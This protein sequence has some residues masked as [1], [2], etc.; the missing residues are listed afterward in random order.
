VLR[1]A[2]SVVPSFLAEVLEIA[3][4]NSYRIIG[5][6][7]TFQQHVASLALAR[8]LRRTA[9]DAVIVFGG[10]NCEGVMGSTLLRAF[11]FIDAVCSGEADLAFPQFAASIIK[12]AKAEEKIPGISLRT[13]CLI[14]SEPP[15]R[16]LIRDLGSLP[17]PDF[18]DYFS[19]VEVECPG[20]QVEIPFETSRGC[21]WGEKSHC[22]FCGL[23]G[24]GMS[25]RQK[26]AAR[27]RDEL[28]ILYA[29]YSDK[30]KSFVAV[31]NILPA[32]TIG[33]LFP[34]L[35]KLG[36][37]IFFE[38]KAN[39]TEEQLRV[40]A[41]AGVKRIQPGIESLSSSALKKMRKGA[42]AII[43]LRFLRLCAQHGITPYWNYLV[44]FPG[45]SGD[46]YRGVADLIDAI[47]HLAPPEN[48]VWTEVRVDRFSPYF[49]EPTR[50]GIER[51]YPYPSYGSVYWGLSEHEISN[52][53]YFFI[54]DVAEPEPRNADYRE[55]LGDALKDWDQR[56][57][58][59]TLLELD[60]GE[61]IWLFGY[62]S[63]FGTRLFSVPK[64]FMAAYR[65][66]RGISTITNAQ[67][68]TDAADEL[69]QWLNEMVGRRFLWKEGNQYVSL[70]IPGRSGY[71]PPMEAR[72][73]FEKALRDCDVAPE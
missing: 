36:I 48:G 60:L 49:M 4:W 22:T 29:K 17:I 37:E 2:R 26:S 67:H 20:E 46:D 3:D 51:L 64:R 34:E 44:G 9:P 23:N 30:S 18:D 41:A 61:S 10:A 50:F 11:D 35:G 71:A 73:A 1:D 5:F 69:E 7:S 66:C 15:R 16:P 54:A 58:S 13:D 21:W 31:D 19:R 14:E 56:H 8:L 68:L 32:A 70:A 62:D 25:F 57:K 45:E 38:V 40:M 33:D 12:G 55:E 24:M 53:A 65:A 59:S 43:N 63:K 42:S 52:L 28:Y 72:S 39:L 6:S 47:P 27:A